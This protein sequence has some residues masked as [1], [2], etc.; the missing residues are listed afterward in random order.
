MGK[1]SNQKKSSQSIW[2]VAGIAVVAVGALVG[3][4]VYSSQSKAPKVTVTVKSDKEYN[5]TR[6]AMGP[7]TAKVTLTEYTDYL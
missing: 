7:A 5:A 4:S 1:K 3:V 6:N 2:V